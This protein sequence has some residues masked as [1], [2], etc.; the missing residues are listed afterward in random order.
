MWGLCFWHRD[1]YYLIPPQKQNKINK[2]MD[3]D[4]FPEWEHDEL[5]RPLPYETGENLYIHT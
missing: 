3:R 2:W 4:L 1:M 5:Y